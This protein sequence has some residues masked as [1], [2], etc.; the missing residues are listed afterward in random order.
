[1]FAGI[2][3][4]S[5]SDIVGCYEGIST[6]YCES[7]RTDIFT[8]FWSVHADGK[9][10]SNKE[11]K[12]REISIE[13][14]VTSAISTLSITGLPI[15]D[16]VI[17]VCN[18]VITGSYE[19]DAQSATFTVSDIPPVTDLNVE[20]ELNLLVCTWS[21]PLCLPIDYVYDIK[22][23]FDNMTVNHNTTELNYTQEVGPCRNNY[24]VSV[25]VVSTGQTQYQSMHTVVSKQSNNSAGD[26]M[27]QLHYIIIIF[28]IVNVGRQNR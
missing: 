25:Q 12:M 5:I 16:G 10:L 26:K 4:S 2:I 8:I 24:I 18:A 28:G 14:N 1:M 7:N 20:F 27:N 11:M 22:I 17:V 9:S 3:T 21:L 15:N 13:T 19:S 23:T 6:F